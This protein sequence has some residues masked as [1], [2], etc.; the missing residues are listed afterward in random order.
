MGNLVIVLN[1]S[2]DRFHFLYNTLEEIRSIPTKS[3][4]TLR[5]EPS[6]SHL[7]CSVNKDDNIVDDVEVDS[8]DGKDIYSEDNLY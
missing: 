8:E 6:S 7:F 4:Q 1:D 5:I 2:T 3:K